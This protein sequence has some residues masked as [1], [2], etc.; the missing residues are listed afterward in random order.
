MSQTAT[1]AD[2]DDHAP[3]IERAGKH[4]WGYNIAQ[5]DEFLD[6]THSMY[7]SSTPVLTQE[8]IQ[9]ASFDLEKNGYVI[10]QVD[11]VLIR[12]EKAV[13]DQRTQFALST[14]GQSA[15]Q[16]DLL[17]LA[18]TLQERAEAEPKQ[19][20]DRGTHRQPSYDMKQ[21]D[22]IVSQAWT[23]IA[24]QIGIDTS[25]QSA[26]GA[27]EITAQRVS[28]VIFTQRK[29]R[30]G[31][32][33]ASVDAYLNRCVQVL[34][35]I[36]SFGRV[37]GRPLEPFASSVVGTPVPGLSDEN[38]DGNDDR[39]MAAGTADSS[40]GAGSPQEGA[41]PMMPVSYDG[42]S[43]V[44]DGKAEVP[45]TYA[46]L[47]EPSAGQD[48]S[49]SVPSQTQDS[50]WG[51]A[52][53]ASLVSVPSATTADGFPDAAASQAG[54]S[55]A[56]QFGSSDTGRFPVP[57]Q[58][59]SL[60]GFTDESDR[61][62]GSS[63]TVASPAETTGS[64]AAVFPARRGDAHDGLADEPHVPDGPA[65]QVYTDLQAVPDGPDEDSATGAAH[66]GQESGSGYISSLLNTPVASTGTFEIPDLTFPVS[67]ATQKKDAGDHDDK[68]DGPSSPEA[69]G[70]EQPA[71]NHA[72]GDQ[73]E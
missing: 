7:E 69:D 18:R 33:E 73:S 19:R 13:V 2:S 20:F 71:R 35:R 6:R 67:Q 27:Q 55:S 44:A 3:S 38:S 53:L 58:A 42:P 25:A 24:E 63:Q 26:E 5:V 16:K 56:G 68:A 70:S 8:D 48:S 40:L 62:A 66:N 37:A 57:G 52:G 39:P 45:D 51:S 1:K 32:G 36:E 15:W 9:L 11:A 4:K 23:R 65:Q 60:N 17:A 49:Q 61:Q 41:V 22:Q 28:N 50:G 64:L 34:T 47:P 46:P 72:D 10:S 43:A 59:G 21:V 31:Y 29:G 12:L 30:H 54:S 14:T